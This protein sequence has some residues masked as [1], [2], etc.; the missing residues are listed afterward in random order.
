MIRINLLPEEYRRKART[1]IKIL[2]TLVGVVA[3]NSAL[4]AYWCWL[5]FGV[6]SEIDTER[7]V[8]QLEMDG[9]TPRVNYHH[10]LDAETKLYAS[11]EKTLA[12]ITKNRVAWTKKLDELIDVVHSGNDGVRHYVW[13]DDIIVKQTAGGARRRG[14]TQAFG[15][16]KSGGHSGS[17]RWNQVANFL[18]DIE[19]HELSDF[20]EDF[21]KPGSPEGTLSPADENL[22]PAINW[23]FPLTMEL[24]SPDE[25]QKARLL[26][27]SK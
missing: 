7:S 13:F 26:K 23:S 15:S 24:K 27:E 14:A 20:I 3:V 1:P 8:L 17:P 10:A 19:D 25:R 16:L 11:R 9:L 2:L 5:A 4:L 22:I 12:E 21:N 6:M 18:E